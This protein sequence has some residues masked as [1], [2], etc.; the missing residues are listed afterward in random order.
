MKTGLLVTASAILGLA[1][2]SARADPAVIAATDTAPAGSSSATLPP[3][4]SSMPELALPPATPAATV[5]TGPLLTYG[6]TA[7]SNYIFRGVSQTENRPAIFGAAR[8]TYD[9]FYAGIG[10]ENVDF[11]NGTNAEYDLSAGWAPVVRAFRFDFG[12]IRYGYIDEPAH[13]HID[14]VEYKAAV[15]HDF[16]PVTVGGVVYDTANFFGSGHNG[17]YFAARGTYRFT[18]QLSISGALG[19]QTVNQGTDHTTWNA[20]L[21]YSVTKNIALDLRYYDTNTHSLGDTYG[22]HYVAAIKVSF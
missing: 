21:D 14:T 2:Q 15:S 19:R 17:A 16:G 12:V 10:A 22:A 11:H 5:S 4:T 8:L 18:Q 13:T 1:G 20:G 3:D 6:A 7:A 9:Q